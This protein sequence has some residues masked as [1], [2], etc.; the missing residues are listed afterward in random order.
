MS[1]LLEQTRKINELLQQN[2]TFNTDSDLPYGEMADVLGDILNSNTYIISADGSVLGFAEIL[3]VNNERVKNMFLQKQF[4][5][6]YANMVDQLKSTE[7]N[8]TIESDMTAF[9][10]ELRE[11]YPNGLTTVVPIFGAGERLGTIILS[12]I[13][14]PFDDDDLVLAEYSATVVGMQILYQKSRSIEEDV[15]STTAVQ[16]AVGTLSYSELKAVQAIFEALDGDE[17]RLTASNIADQIGITRSVI[18]N[19]LRKLESAGII[20]SRSLGMKGTY[21]KVL[22]HRFK[23]ELDKA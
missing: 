18:V 4:P 5:T 23:D 16:M 12:R 14:Q 3:D 10:V 21:L 17:G 20:E 11:K 15:R 8:I 7:A 22:N 6:S 19:A 13:E 2:N 1:T 9:P